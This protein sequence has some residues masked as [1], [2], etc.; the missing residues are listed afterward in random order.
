MSFKPPSEEDEGNYKDLGQTNYLLFLRHRRIRFRPPFQLF[1]LK[2][3]A[4]IFCQIDLASHTTES[5]LIEARL[6]YGFD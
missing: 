1:F 3:G 6:R 5:Y 2:N 4:H